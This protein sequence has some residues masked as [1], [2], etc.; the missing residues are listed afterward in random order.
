MAEYVY[1]KAG[2]NNDKDRVALWDTNYDHPFTDEYP[3]GGE[4]FVA[5]S[6]PR[7]AA[8]TP[9]VNRAI[10]DG[11]LVEVKEADAINNPRVHQ[12]IDPNTMKVVSLSKASS[13][14]TVPADDVR[15][16]TSQANP[17][18]TDTSRTDSSAAVGSTSSSTSAS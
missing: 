8:R 13:P 2:P 10:H 11:V 7:I 9:A 5:G 4:V 3:D 18:T 15:S 16:S 6:L 1:V 12:P 14:S 17:S